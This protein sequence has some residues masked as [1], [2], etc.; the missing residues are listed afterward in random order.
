MGGNALKIPTR[1]V[2]TTEYS[3]IDMEVSNILYDE[4]IKCHTTQSFE[5]K[6]TFGDLDILISNKSFAKSNDMYDFIVKNYRPKDVHRNKGVISFEYK[7][8]QVDFILIDD[9]HWEASKV[10]YSYNDLGNLMGRISYKMGFRYGH[11]G[12]RVNYNSPHGGKTL[13]IYVSR[14]PKEIFNFLGFDYE[15]FNNGFKDLDEIFR[16]VMYSKYYTP[17][18]FQY[19]SLNHQNKTRNKKRANYRG[20]LEYIADEKTLKPLDLGFPHHDFIMEGEKYFDIELKSKIKEFDDSIIEGKRTD[21]TAERLNKENIEERFDI[22][23]KKLGNAI[24][25]F[26]KEVKNEYFIDWDLF[27]ETNDIDIIM[28]HF[29]KYNNLKLKQK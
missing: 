20:F 23:G 28:E 19:E 27:V 14:D 9:K 17:S 5:S 25:K 12:L 4:N 10:Y 7:D 29:A 18:I 2:D 11:E 6:E 1:R 8:F 3:I 26:K 24:T 13:K 22:K 15:R 16:Y 21:L